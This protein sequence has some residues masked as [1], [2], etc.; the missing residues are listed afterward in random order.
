MTS[1]FEIAEIVGGPWDGATYRRVGERFP[2]QLPLPRNG[3]VFLY[4]AGMGHMGNPVYRFMGRFETK[5]E[6]VR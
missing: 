5:L 4:V 3:V 6:A 1:P 2:D